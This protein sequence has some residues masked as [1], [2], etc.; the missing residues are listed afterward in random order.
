MA[1]ALLSLLLGLLVFLAGREMF[2]VGAG[3]FALAL[4]VFEPNII[5]HGAYVTTDMGLSCFMF[6]GIY[7]L[8]RY[9]KMPSGE[10][11]DYVGHS[12]WV[13]ARL[14]TLSCAFTSD[15]PVTS[16]Y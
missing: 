16:L 5:A 10:Q 7:V 3:L 11:T 6:A 12:I 4:F 15:R 9:V 14:E 13:G 2:G 1:A 8:Y